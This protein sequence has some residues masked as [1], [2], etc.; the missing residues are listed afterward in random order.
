MDI[1]LLLLTYSLG[2]SLSLLGHN[3]HVFPGS[4]LR[5][6][7]VRDGYTTRRRAEIELASF[8]RTRE[9]YVKISCAGAAAGDSSSSSGTE[10]GDA[11]DEDVS[12][13]GIIDGTWLGMKTTDDS[14]Q[15][16]G[17]QQQVSADNSESAG[18]S[19]SS[20]SEDFS[21]RSSKL[22]KLLSRV[23]NEE[24]SAAAN[25]AEAQDDD[26][27]TLLVQIQGELMEPIKEEADS[28][29]NSLEVKRMR[30]EKLQE[31]FNVFNSGPDPDFFLPIDDMD[32]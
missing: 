9:G 18:H 2:G 15:L 23:D 13:F 24:D 32:I 17:G 21:L 8:A 10:D 28:R 12:G 3:I 30:D 7:R 14:I 16:R 31:D 4:S 25:T 26:I 6:D 5:V 27:E 19:S 29:S 11:D 22:S 1:R 20:L